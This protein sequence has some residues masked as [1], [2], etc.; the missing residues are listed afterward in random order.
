[1]SSVDYSRRLSVSFN[2]KP[3]SSEIKN[4]INEPITGS[5]E[6]S[7][8]IENKENTFPWSYE[9]KISKKRTVFNLR[10]NGYYDSAFKYFAEKTKAPS[11]QDFLRSII[12]RHIDDLIE[13]EANN[14]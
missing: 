7:K 9:D 1:M 11:Y 12:E 14:L 4:F 13:K 6:Y 3:T 5:N 2:K 8:P 10:L